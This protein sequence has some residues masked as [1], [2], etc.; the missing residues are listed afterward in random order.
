[1]SGSPLSHGVSTWTMQAQ[2]DRAVTRNAQLLVSI[3]SLVNQVH[4]Q[5]LGATP[6]TTPSRWTCTHPTCVAVTKL[7]EAMS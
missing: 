6:H 7:I 2:L 3:R 1:M 5:G 4:R